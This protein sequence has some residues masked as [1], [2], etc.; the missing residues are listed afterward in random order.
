[1]IVLDEIELYSGFCKQRAIER[2]GEKS[3]AVRVALRANDQD[4]GDF[5]TFNFECHRF[6][7]LSSAMIAVIDPIA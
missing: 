6:T 1:V 3:A 7:K 2:F 4:V 5:E